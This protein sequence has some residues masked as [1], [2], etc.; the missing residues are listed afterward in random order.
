MSVELRELAPQVRDHKLE[1]RHAPRSCAMPS[2]SVVIPTHDRASLLARAIDSALAQEDVA[3]EV[4]VIV[5][6]D[7]STD[8]TREV[9]EGYG[10]AI[11]WA[12]QGNAGPA[13]ARNRG[14]AMARGDWIAFL[15][16]DD[17]WVPHKLARQLPLTLGGHGLVYSDRVDLG[18][19]S[20]WRG[21]HSQRVKFWEGD[22]FEPLLMGNFITLSSVLM[23]RSWFERLGGFDETLWGTEDW[24]LWLKFAERAPVALCREPLTRYHRHAG[25][26]SNDPARMRQQHMRVLDRALA[27]PRGRALSDAARRR[28]LSRGWEAS[29]SWAR[30]AGRLPALA[31]LARCLGYWPGNLGACRRVLRCCL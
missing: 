20:S 9:L 16:S 19:L 17:E 25:A 7:G 29:A 28:A 3:S 26:L 5:V 21:L 15:D 18:A 23:Q 6:D 2:V 13:A 14:V 10:D 12:R 4:E 30:R 8:G 22:V 31:C 1:R 27:S 24:D 11:R